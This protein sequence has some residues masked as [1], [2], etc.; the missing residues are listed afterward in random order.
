MDKDLSN[1]EIEKKLIEFQ[2]LINQHSDMPKNFGKFGYFE[3]F[4]RR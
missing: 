4:P 1:D 3:F 2:D